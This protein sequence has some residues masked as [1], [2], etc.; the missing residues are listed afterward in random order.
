MQHPYT[1]FCAHYPK[2]SLLLSPCIQPPLYPLHPPPSSKICFKERKKEERSKLYSIPYG[3]LTKGGEVSWKRQRKCVSFCSQ[4]SNCE[5]ALESTAI[6]ICHWDPLLITQSVLTLHYC[7]F[8]FTLNPIQMHLSGLKQALLNRSEFQKDGVETAALHMSGVQQDFGEN[9]ERN[10]LANV[11]SRIQ[12]FIY[13]WICWK[14][15]H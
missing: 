13:T 5:H 14:N 10:G 3:L 12:S 7:Y 15:E 1:L 2:S 6:N 11:K 9:L 4:Q 8:S